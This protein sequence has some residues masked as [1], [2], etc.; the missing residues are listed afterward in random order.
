MLGV[1]AAIAVGIGGCGRSET[2]GDVRVV[3]PRDARVTGIAK[4]CGASSQVCYGIRSESVSVLDSNGR[5]AAS[6]APNSRGLFS[7]SLI[8]GRY[9]V[10]LNVNGAELAQ[11]DVNAMP[12]RTAHTDLSNPYIR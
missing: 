1:T 7:F 4:P 3:L 11:A 6:S 10:V 12:H 2:L 9:E 8:P 5:I